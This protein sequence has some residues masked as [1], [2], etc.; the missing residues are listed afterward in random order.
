MKSA[1]GREVQ[2]RRWTSRNAFSGPF[3]PNF[4][5]GMDQVLR[6]GMEGSSKNISGGTFLYNLPC[7]HDGD[8][9]GNL[10]MDTHIV[11]HKDDGTLKFFLHFP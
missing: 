2:G 7:V 3:V 9:V 6:V 1:T 11:G 8:P 4:G 10:S 5:K